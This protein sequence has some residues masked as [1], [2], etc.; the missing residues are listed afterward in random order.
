M[1]GTMILSTISFI[2]LFTCNPADKK[3]LTEFKGEKGT[4]EWQYPTKDKEAAWK[5]YLPNK[6]GGEIFLRRS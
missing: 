3:K 6:P 5:H 4:F 1:K 2:L